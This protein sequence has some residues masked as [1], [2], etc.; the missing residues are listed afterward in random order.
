MARRLKNAVSTVASF[1][2]RR[3]RRTYTYRELQDI[4]FAERENWELPTGTSSRKFVEFLLQNTKFKVISLTSEKYRH[5]VERFAWGDVSVYSLALS[6]RR[7]SYLSH[8]TAVFLHALTDQIPAIVYVNIEQSEKPKPTEALT[9]AGIDRAFANKQRR[10]NYIFLTDHLQIVLLSGKQTG[11]LGVVPLQ[12]PGGEPLIATNLERT[13]VDIAVRPDYAGGVYHVLQA[14][15]AAKDK[16]S[17]NTVLAIL[18]KLDYVYPYHQAIGFY[19]QKAGYETERFERLRKLPV[20]FDFYL[21]HNM[22]ETA[23]DSHWRLFFPKGF[24]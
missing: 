9:Q 19:M 3:D 15:R 2:D 24:E 13:L 14:Y 21:A 16:M 4:L 23:Y 7:R 5:R 6:I 22:R 20:N 18:K 10:S 8:A 17:V 12:G 1:F 11:Q